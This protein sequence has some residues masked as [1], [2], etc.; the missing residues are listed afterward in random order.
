VQREQTVGSALV[1]FGVTLSFML[2]VALGDV[3]VGIVIGLPLIIAGVVFFVR[4]QRDA[5]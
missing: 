1:V 3:F 5:T 4:A 2:A